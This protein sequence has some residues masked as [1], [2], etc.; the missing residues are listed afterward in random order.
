MRAFYDYGYQQSKA[1]R[2]WHKLP[3]TLG[4]ELGKY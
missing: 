1:G 2:E 4:S 3:P